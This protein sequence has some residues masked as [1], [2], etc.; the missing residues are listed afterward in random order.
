MNKRV[1][2]GWY[3]LRL[4]EPAI[5]A[6]VEPGQFVE[7]LTSERGAL[8]PMLRRP[9]SVYWADP[10]EG[11]YDILYTTTGRGTRWL[12]D[13]P[14]EPPGGPPLELDVLG[15]LGNRFTPPLSGER[16]Y[17][18][19]GGVGVAPLYFLARELCAGQRPPDITLCMGARTAAQLQGIEDFRRLPIRSESA[20]DDGSAGYRG[21]VTALLEKLLD[22]LPRGEAARARVYGCGPSGMNEALR[23]VVTARGI[24]CE[25]CLEARMA[26]GFGICFA[27]V[28]PIRK[29]LGGPFYNRRI[30]WEG[31]VFDARLLKA[32]GV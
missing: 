18:V 28:H 5:A 20:T 10:A 30:C 31:P 17:L 21:V 6:A 16:V 19:G 12:A 1:G 26:C 23:R 7:I 32:G 11:T 27:C 15:P 24:A 8:D 4:R 14:V 29:E 25:I 9:M 13:L 2:P 22:E 3:L